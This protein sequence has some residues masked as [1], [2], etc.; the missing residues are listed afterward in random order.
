M[1]IC[2]AVAGFTSS[3]VALTESVHWLAVGVLVF[4]L[5]EQYTVSFRQRY[6]LTM[7][8]RPTD[9]RNARSRY[10]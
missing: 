2:E 8:R 10:R 4:P 6:C 7:R 5:F 3:G 9:T 1:L